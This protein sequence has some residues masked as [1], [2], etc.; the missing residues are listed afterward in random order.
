MSGD[1]HKFNS[2]VHRMNDQRTSYGA[3]DKYLSNN[4]CVIRQHSLACD[5]NWAHMPT[6]SGSYGRP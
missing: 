3:E 1:S 5:K 6:A 4:I 2:A